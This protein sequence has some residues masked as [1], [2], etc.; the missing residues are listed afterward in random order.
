LISRADTVFYLAQYFVVAVSV[1]SLT[2]HQC[3]SLFPS[4]SHGSDQSSLL[5]RI[6]TNEFRFGIGQTNL[7]VTNFVEVLRQTTNYI[8]VDKFTTNFLPVNLMPTYQSGQKAT[9]N[10]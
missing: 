9:P 7:F 10:K 3:W 6:N 5:I 2:I 1:A 8:R 4:K